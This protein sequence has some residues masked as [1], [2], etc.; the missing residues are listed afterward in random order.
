MNDYKAYDALVFTQWI[1]LR[2]NKT[3]QA[4]LECAAQNNST[5]PHEPSLDAWLG[6][7]P[8]LDA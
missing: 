8:S 6:A 7:M 5:T 2:V 3:A 1:A 4:Q